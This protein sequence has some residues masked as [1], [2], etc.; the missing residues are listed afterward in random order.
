MKE[1]QRIIKY[2]AMTF[3]VFLIFNIVA[4]IMLTINTIGNIFYNDDISYEKL[5]MVDLSSQT[6]ALNIEVSSVN[7]YI[8]EGETFKVETDSDFIK[9]T[10]DK[11]Q[12]TIEE[13]EHNWLFST[14]HDD[15]I[16]YIPKEVSFDSVSLNT[17]IGKI[18]IDALYT[19]NLY[20]EQGAGKI[21]IAYLGVSESANLNGGVG[22][23]TIGDGAI[24][25]LSLKTGVAKTS[26]TSK[27]LGNSHIESGLG[28]LDL[29]L[30]GEEAAYQLEVDQGIG[31]MDVY[32]LKKNNQYY[33]Y[34][35][36]FISIDGG[37]G[38]IHIQLKNK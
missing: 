30:L 26:I 1:V 20:L 19:K 18:K 33:G 5:K 7:V 4:S 27:I 11:K 10:Q 13:E 37:I 12:I 21:D 31:S 22:E 38:S 17:K 2:V 8:K 32:G 16:I 3:A 35:E 14:H 36:N 6:T 29:T 9:S 25:Q 24:Q 15:L 28:S 34:G 23:L